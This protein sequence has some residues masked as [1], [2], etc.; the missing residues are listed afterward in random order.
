MLLL[1]MYISTLSS[2]NGEYMKKVEKNFGGLRFPKR[3]R[4]SC[5][6]LSLSFDSS[7]VAVLPSGSDSLYVNGHSSSRFTA[8]DL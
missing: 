1:Y 5:T 8:P 4:L 2:K 7:V 6:A 3:P